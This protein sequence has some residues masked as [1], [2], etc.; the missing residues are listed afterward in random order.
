M[1]KKNDKKTTNN[2][3][4]SWLDHAKEQARS[5]LPES[6][7]PIGYFSRH[8]L[9]LTGVATKIVLPIAAA[10]IGSAAVITGASLVSTYVMPAMFAWDLLTNY[11]QLD[12]RKPETVHPILRLSQ[13][14][15]FHKA[16][17]FAIIAATVTG[18][19][20]TWEAYAAGAT[21]SSAIL[22][23]FTVA[24]LAPTA[25]IVGVGTAAAAGILTLATHAIQ[26]DRN[27]SM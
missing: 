8:T 14:D 21:V 5:Y 16:G 23:A 11:V 19:G 15:V 7:Y 20:L 4:K 3:K 12:D 24:N 10:K 26:Q 9:L 6:A 17:T 18:L 22:E 2:G 1:P 25:F 27:F 13:A